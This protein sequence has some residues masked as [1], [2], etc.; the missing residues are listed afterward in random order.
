MVLLCLLWNMNRTNTFYTR[1]KFNKHLFLKTIYFKDLKV[2][3]N[4][5]EKI[6]KLQARS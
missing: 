6:I 3:Y 1:H 5:C 2:R 4:N